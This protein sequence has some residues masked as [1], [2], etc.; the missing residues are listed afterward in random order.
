MRIKRKR[1]KKTITFEHPTDLDRERSCRQLGGKEL[2]QPAHSLDLVCQ[3][4]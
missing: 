2:P 3:N 1:P 4:I